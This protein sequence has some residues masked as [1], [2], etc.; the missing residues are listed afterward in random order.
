MKCAKSKVPCEGYETNIFYSSLQP[1]LL[2]PKEIDLAQPLPPTAKFL[3]YEEF[4]YFNYFCDETAGKLSWYSEGG[5][6]NNTIPQACHS[7]LSLR[8]LTIS[9]AALRKAQN[10][11]EEAASHQ[12][13]AFRQYGKA[14]KEVQKTI[15]TRSEP[16][17]T[18]IA[19]ISSLLIYCFENLQG[20][21]TQAQRHMEAAL[22]LVCKRLAAPKHSFS[23]LD[24][25]ATLP[26]VEH[27]HLST[28]VRIDSSFRY[29]MD[30]LEDA[31]ST[32]HTKYRKDISCEIPTK[33][34]SLL[35]ARSYLEHLQYSS[36]G[37][38]AKSHSVHPYRNPRITPEDE[39]KEA[40]ARRLLRSQLEE[41]HK[42]FAPLLASVTDENMPVAA[43]LQ[44]L[45]LGSNILI[46]NSYRASNLYS[47]TASL[48]SD[49]KQ[50]VLLCRTVVAHPNF[51]KKFVFD[52]GIVPNLFLVITSWT[53]RSIKEEAVEVCWAAE[54]RREMVWDARLVARFGEG[55]LRKEI[56]EEENEVQ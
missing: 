12:E 21:Y 22:E 30:G 7:E 41:W 10:G 20:D 40:F 17:A 16:D 51:Q 43:T 39:M 6:W 45:A 11:D 49:A 26:C 2:Q 15:N 28:L 13:F 1:R 29:R 54:G 50:I 46:H 9:V 44:A 42:A 53:K 48:D 23:Y 55:M 19:L 52:W 35:E 18:R 36:L 8:S 5:F 24:N 34:A 25:T 14:L 4:Q 37:A 33:F 3:N 47:E 32:L 27:E 56:E 31:V 38:L